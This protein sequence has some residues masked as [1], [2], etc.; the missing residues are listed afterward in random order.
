MYRT[1]IVAFLTL[2]MIFS[3]CAT[4]STRTIILDD[5]TI[6][7]PARDNEGPDARI[8][9]CKK[10]ST[11]SG[12][13]IG[14]GVI[15]EINPK[16]NLRTII[17]INDLPLEKTTHLFH[18]DWINPYGRS[19]FLKPVLIHASDTAVITS[20]ISLSPETRDTGQYLLRLYYFREL[21]AEKYFTLVP[22]DGLDEAIIKAEAF[23]SEKSDRDTIGLSDG[24]NKFKIRKK[25]RVYAHVILHNLNPEDDEKPIKVKLE[26][27]DSNEKTFFSKKMEFYPADTLEYL[28]SSIG[29]SPEKRKAG[30]YIFRVIFMGNVLAEKHFELY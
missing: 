8:T 30:K 29:I 5:G 22:D 14:S 7:Y 3:G 1:W 11:R 12:K 25:G 23:L 10:I 27:S 21:I 6:Q 15:F 19:F 26:W 20:S 16:N 2:L 24:N 18:I 4:R 13:P 17:H 9:F 28:T